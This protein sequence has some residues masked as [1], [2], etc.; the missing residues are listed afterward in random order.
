MERGGDSHGDLE[1]REL[2]RARITPPPKTTKEC[3]SSSASSLSLAVFHSSDH[4]RSHLFFQRT[5]RFQTFLGSEQGV[6]V[7]VPHFPTASLVAT[8]ET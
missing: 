2:L 6:V 5:R 7:D 1:E 8:S 3:A 4:L